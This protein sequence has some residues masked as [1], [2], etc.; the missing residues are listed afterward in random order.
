MKKGEIALFQCKPVY[1]YGEEGKFPKIPPNATLI[2]EIEVFDWDADLTKKKDGGI[3]K[4][5]TLNIGQGSERPSIG[6]TVDI[7]VTGKYKGRIF[8]NRDVKFPLGEGK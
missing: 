4:S 8:E 7:H 2:F 5:A 3:W 6:S 1:A